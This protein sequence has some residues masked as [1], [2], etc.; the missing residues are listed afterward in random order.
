MLDIKLSTLLI[1]SLI[2]LTFSIKPLSNLSVSFPVNIKE[3]ASNT[4]PIDSLIS[5]I[6]SIVSCFSPLFSPISPVNVKR[7]KENIFFINPHIPFTSFR[8]LLTCSSPST[9]SSARALVI[10]LIGPTPDFAYSIAS[11]LSSVSPR[12]LLKNFVT[13]P[14]IPGAFPVFSSPSN[15]SADQKSLTFSIAPGRFSI[16]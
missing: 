4:F 2:E 7:I 15:V 3:I 14:I 8:D 6:L 5:L 11:S 16:I 13:L 12:I 1:I 9:D 10:K